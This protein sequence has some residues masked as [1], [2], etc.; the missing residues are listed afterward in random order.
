MVGHYMSTIS[1][2]E[3]DTFNALKRLP[4]ETLTKTVWSSEHRTKE[5]F[6]SYLESQN[7]TYTEFLKSAYRAHVTMGLSHKCGFKELISY[8]DFIHYMEITLY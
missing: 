2:N 5:E 1:V 6:I 7:W 3:D 8:P 4:Y